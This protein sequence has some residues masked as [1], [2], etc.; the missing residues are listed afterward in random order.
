MA[1]TTVPTSSTLV[2]FIILGLSVIIHGDVVLLTTR[3]INLSFTVSG[4]L[5]L[6]P[7]IVV[8]FII[9]KKQNH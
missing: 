2:L 8:D 3:D 5:F 6:V 7:A 1:L 4:W 9:K